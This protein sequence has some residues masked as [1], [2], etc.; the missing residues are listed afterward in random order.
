MR[1]NVFF[2]VMLMMVS[3]ACSSASAKS[4]R[5]DIHKGHSGDRRE[6]RMRMDKGGRMHMD[7]PRAKGYR[8]AYA[9]HHHVVAVHRPAPHRHVVSHRVPPCVD[10]H[11]YLPGWHGRVRYV[12]GR[13][14]YLR[15][16]D[17]YWYDEYFEPA[18]YF[19]H[20]VAH[21][22]GHL[23]PAGKVVAGAVGAAAVGALIGALCR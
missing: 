9:G 2:L 14:G 3:L 11:G 10:H 18:Y 15:G 22:H 1:R 4:R 17:W 7:A 6:M 20:P 16:C 19:S 12:N 21:F 23:S 5:D 8:P 13:W